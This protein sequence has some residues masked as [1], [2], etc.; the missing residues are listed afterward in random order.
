MLHH[1]EHSGNPRKLFFQKVS[2]WRIVYNSPQ[3]VGWREISEVTF[4]SKS[5]L[6]ENWDNSPQLVGW[7]E[8]SEVTF[9]SKSFLMENWI[10]WGQSQL[11]F[12]RTWG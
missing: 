7:R 11:F 2:S 9:F 6:M 5:F 4:F 3:L 1:N 10:K 8:I 12:G